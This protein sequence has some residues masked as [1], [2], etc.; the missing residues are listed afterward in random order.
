MCCL[1]F[2]LK[3]LEQLTIDLL[4]AINSPM[5]ST[6]M[7]STPDESQSSSSKSKTTSNSFNTP[8]LSKS[9]K[10]PATGGNEPNA[11]AVTTAMKQLSNS[12]NL[13]ETA[14][15]SPIERE[16]SSHRLATPQHA[17]NTAS[18][19]RSDSI[20]LLTP[21]SM[22]SPP[23][24]ASAAPSSSS[25]ANSSNLSQNTS[26]SEN[27]A[28]LL[29]SSPIVHSQ[30]LTLIDDSFKWIRLKQVSCLDKLPLEASPFSF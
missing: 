19:L 11:A 17:A 16:D 20:L 7:T 25:C 27:S 26:T 15:I 21:S 18:S 5:A 23:L 6:L 3:Q 9:R 24:S 29:N 12:T 1:L 13:R 28:Q 4:V 8:N 14:L 30:L 2:R 10:N 22:L